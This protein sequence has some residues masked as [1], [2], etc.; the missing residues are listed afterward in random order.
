VAELRYCWM[1]P[2][3]SFVLKFYPSMISFE[4]LH[5][6]LWAL[7]LQLEPI[8]SLFLLLGVVGVSLVHH[9]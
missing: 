2:K 4:G 5:F 9:E 6:Y 1:Q 8:G 7:N 3:L